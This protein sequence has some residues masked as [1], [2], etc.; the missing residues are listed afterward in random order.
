MKK[1]KHSCLLGTTDSKQKK[2]IQKIQITEFMV[3]TILILFGLFV[4][5]AF[6]CIM[7]E[8]GTIGSDVNVMQGF[9]PHVKMLSLIVCHVNLVKKVHCHLYGTI[10]HVSANSLIF[11]VTKP[12]MS[13]EDQL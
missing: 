4:V 7:I 1:N 11:C 2:N 8:Q 3:L 10:G 13:I 12:R 9:D 5:S 6:I